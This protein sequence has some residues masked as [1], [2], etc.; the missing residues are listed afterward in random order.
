M[1]TIEI[2]ETK[3]KF[4]IPEDLSECNTNQYINISALLYQVA[5]G[6]LTKEGFQV[7][8][9]HHLILK[10]AKHQAKENDDKKYENIYAIAAA[11]DSFFEYDENEKPILKQYFIHN[12]IQK[13]RGATKNYYGPTDEFNNVTFGEYVDALSFYYDYVET[14]DDQFLYLLFATFYREKRSFYSRN[15]FS[16]DKRVPYN[17]DRLEILSKAFKKQH[18]GVIYGFFLLFSSFQKYLQTATVFVQGKEIDL[19]ILYKDLPNQKKP[20]ES[21]IPGLGMKSILYSISESGVFGS[22]EEVRK[23]KLWEIL[24]RFYDIR[25]RDLDALANQKEYANS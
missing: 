7:Q 24:I 6:E 15:K 14:N 4:Y 3:Q 10:N 9:V 17:P 5:K 2:L 21:T 13:I 18:I 23:T 25:K 1:H 11:L 22:L 19:S 8:A 12:P 16:L 20:K